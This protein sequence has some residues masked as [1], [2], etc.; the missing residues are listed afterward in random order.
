MASSKRPRPRV[1]SPRQENGG[2]RVRLHPHGLELLRPAA[3]GGATRATGAADAP[4]V[5]PAGDI[6]PLWAGA[7]HYWRHRP[8]EWGAGLD[9][10]VA[11]GLRVLDTYVPWGVHERAPGDLD[12]GAH[13]P[14]L[15]VRRFLQMAHQ[16][17]LKVVLRPGPHIN[18]ELTYFGL[19]ER[20]VWDPACQA[21]TPRNHPVMLPI[22]PVAFPVPSYASDVF[23]EE[24]ALWFQAVGAQ[25]ADLRHPEGPIV[26]VQIDNEGA[27]YFRDGPYDQDYHPDAI[28]LFRAFLKRKYPTA[29]DLREAWSAPSILHATAT[30]PQRFDARGADDLPRHMDWMEFHE[31]LLADAMGRMARAAQGTGLDELPTM[32]NFPLGE[33]ATPLNARRMTESIDLIGLDYYHRATPL[34]HATLLRRTTELAARCEGRGAPAYGA[35]VG[36]GFPPFFAPIDEKDS[37]YTLMAAL[38]YGMRG[39]NLYMA[40]ERDR[41]VGAP[42]D[43]HGKA[44]PFAAAYARLNAALE[45]TQ[46]HTLRRRTAVR[47]VVPGL[48]RRL[49]R[50]T[51]AFGPV[52]PAFF[53][54]IGAGFGE[55][56]LEEDLGLGEVATLV[57]EQYLRAFERALAARGVPFAYVSDS[58]D[59]GVRGAKWIVCATVG[60]LKPELVAQLRAAHDAGVRVTLGPRVPERDGSMRLM[61]VPHDVTGLEVEPL[62]D[63][64]RADALVAR[65]IE[66]LSL[67]TFPVH[68]DGAFVCV[69]EDDDG[70]PRVVF[71]MNPTAHDMPAK[72]SLR[73]VRVLHDLLVPESEAGGASG[74]HARIE[75]HVGA[76]EVVVPAR[77]VR[78]FA[79][80][81]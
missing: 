53:N 1:T 60:G 41:W 32:H 74:P 19:P 30:P 36:A 22:V 42:I 33:A 54:V 14:R 12:F 17:G 61:R 35:E 49:A 48:L 58:F 28:T 4:G 23:H 72:V 75:R 50:A 2:G 21:R 77:T 73:G 79:V 71:V 43:P 13:D 8:E 11:M 29:R 51:H 16:R 57:G 24:T 38:A 15:D 69:H 56:C 37:L 70:A 6:L 7:M 9:A 25:V 27:L 76:F 65:R 78:M 31:H 40:V 3:A 80:E 44:R 5:E 52:T 55:S 62:D 59:D 47:L 46:L 18:A 20:I 45:K 66:E 64:A 26:L 63:A 68:P 39:Y 34:E 10:M 81:A 67:P